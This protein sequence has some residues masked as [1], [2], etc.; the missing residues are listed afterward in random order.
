M[1][2]CLICYFAILFYIERKGLL[3]GNLARILP[4]KS[5]LPGKFQ[6]FNAIDGSVEMLKNSWICKNFN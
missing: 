3:M 5:K 6:C 1:A 2:T 4:L